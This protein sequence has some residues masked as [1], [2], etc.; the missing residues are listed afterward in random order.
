MSSPS[1]Q[2]SMIRKTMRI[3]FIDSIPDSRN[4]V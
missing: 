3:D 4:I 2:M 1:S